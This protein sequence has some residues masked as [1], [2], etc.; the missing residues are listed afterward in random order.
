M[1]A[2]LYDKLPDNIKAIVD[3][4]DDNKDHIEESKRLISELE[5]VNWTGDYDFS[6]SFS[7][8]EIGT[9]IIE[10]FI[11]DDVTTDDD[12]DGHRWSQA[13][14][15]HAKL[16]EASGANIMVQAHG[17]GICG[18]QGCDAESDSYLDF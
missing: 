9:T 14:T 6:G 17:D 12:E 5:K 13:C 8:W 4:Y 7:C 1:T 18:V 16:I 11:F 15:A 3:T 10:G 2:E